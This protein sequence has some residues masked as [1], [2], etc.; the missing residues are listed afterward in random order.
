M[1][2]GTSRGSVGGMETEETATSVPALTAAI[3]KADALIA[4]YARGVALAQE[5]KRTLVLRMLHVQF[6]RMTID[7]KARLM[8]SYGLKP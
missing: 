3:L 5:L 4:H 6:P 7:E 2:S 1:T 8:Q